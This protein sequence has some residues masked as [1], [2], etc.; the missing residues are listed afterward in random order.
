MSPAP[1][2]WLPPAAD[3]EVERA[4]AAFAAPWALEWLP[5]A[6]EVRVQG[7]SA[8]LGEDLSWFGA[9]GAV[10]GVTPAGRSKLAAILVGGQTDPENS[11][12]RDLL[13]RLARAALDD[14]ASRMEQ[15]AG[16]EDPRA[17]GHMTFR[18]SCGDDGALLLLSL[19]ARAR[20]AMRKA[21]AGRGPL[22]ALASL[23]EALAP[24]PIAIG[25]HIGRAELSAGEVA[26]LAPGD[27][28]TFDHR[29]TD[30]LPLTVACQIAAKG[31]AKIL[32]EGEGPAVRIT[33]GPELSL[34]Q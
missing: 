1:E 21:A 8:R 25:C 2:P 3:G 28:I 15:G 10:V 6:E 23:R 12:D 16:G 5:G 17:A 11:V 13:D 30:E 26:G 31:K 14:L 20:T 34:S 9:P 29:L 22:P 4:V 33:Q 7:H 27:L 18:L 19:G 24:E 32:D